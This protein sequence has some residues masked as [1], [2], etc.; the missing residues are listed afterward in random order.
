[1]NELLKL[2]ESP[3]QTGKRIAEAHIPL[4]SQISRVALA[5]DIRWAI[6]QGQIEAQQPLELS[7]SQAATIVYQIVSFVDEYCVRLSHSSYPKQISALDECRRRVLKVHGIE[8]IER[9]PVMS[10]ASQVVRGKAER[11]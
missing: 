9:K 7:R 3:A 4:D 11:A 2:S 10:A 5:E 8:A 6:I 1:M